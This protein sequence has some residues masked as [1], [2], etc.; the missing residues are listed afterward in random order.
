MTSMS[1]STMWHGLG[2]RGANLK[3]RLTSS[4]WLT[5]TTR[6]DRSIGI[7]SPCMILSITMSLRTIKTEWLSR[8]KSWKASIKA[9]NLRQWDQRGC[10]IPTFPSTH[11]AYKTKVAWWRL[12]ISTAI[13]CSRWHQSLNLKARL[14]YQQ[15]WVNSITLL[16][17]T[18]FYAKTRTVKTQTSQKATS[19]CFLPLACL[20]WTTP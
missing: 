1:N 11:P 10:L 6:A 18:L 4:A 15:M 14:R 5:S 20:T 2:S 16:Q 7:P 9:N 3:A 13:R 12:E 19:I 17:T 8:R